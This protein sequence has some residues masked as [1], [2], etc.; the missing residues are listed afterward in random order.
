MLYRLLR[1]GFTLYLR[2]V[3]RLHISGSDLIPASGPAILC[4]NHSS[5]FDSMLVA[6]CTPRPVRFLITERFYRHPV[7]GLVIQR[8]GAIPVTAEGDARHALRRGL[9]VLAE[10]GVLGIFPE[11]RLTR[12]GA[13]GHAESGAA[14]LAAASGAPLVPIAIRGAYDVYPKGKRLPGPGHIRVAVQEPLP[15]EPRR[16]DRAYLRAMTDELM[17]RIGYGLAASDRSSGESR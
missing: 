13:P 3:H 15:V 2:L 9:A 8:C 17:R 14:L 6:L 11:G 16:R 7:L 12:T 10:G 1:I 4:A 5:Y